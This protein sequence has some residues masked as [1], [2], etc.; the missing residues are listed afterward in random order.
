MKN[1]KFLIH[2]I[3]SLTKKDLFI[4]VW[5]LGGALFAYLFWQ[6]E[7][8]RTRRNFKESNAYTNQTAVTLNK[9]DSV[10]QTSKSEDRD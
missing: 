3:E 4:G 6:Y 2:F 9:K 10:L 8:K 5:I 1:D 7:K